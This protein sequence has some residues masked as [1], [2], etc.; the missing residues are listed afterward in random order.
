MD[1]WKKNRKPVDFVKELSFT[2]KRMSKHHKAKSWLY[3]RWM[4]RGFPDLALFQFSPKDLTV[5]LTTPKFRVY[6]AL[7]LSD[8][9][10]LQFELN[11]KNQPA[12]WWKSR[13]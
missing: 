4:V 9:E 13:H 2:V 8:N 6:A 1:I 3:L 12:S 10:N 5:S 11:A 7:G